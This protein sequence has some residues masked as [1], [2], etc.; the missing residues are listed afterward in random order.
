M[1]DE[2]SPVDEAGSVTHSDMTLDGLICAG[3]KPPNLSMVQESG[4]IPSSAA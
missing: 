1:A 4:M 2:L 3:P